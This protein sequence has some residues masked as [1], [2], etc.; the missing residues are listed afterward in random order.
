MAYISSRFLAHRVRIMAHVCCVSAGVLVYLIWSF[1]APCLLRSCWVI[2]KGT[3]RKSFEIYVATVQVYLNNQ[4]VY[5]LDMAWA[6]WKGLCVSIGN[7]VLWGLFFSIS[8]QLYLRIKKQTLLY[9]LGKRQTIIRQI[10]WLVWST[11]WC[12]FLGAFADNCS[13]IPRFSLV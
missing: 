9:S 11:R 12:V 3:Q 8:K 13:P 4:R 7:K 5:L 10:D 6:N 2:K 1:I